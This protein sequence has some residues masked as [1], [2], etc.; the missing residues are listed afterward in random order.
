MVPSTERRLKSRLPVER[1]KNLLPL[2]HRRVRPLLAKVLLELPGLPQKV[3]LLEARQPA[4]AE[5]GMVSRRGRLSLVGA[6]HGMCITITTRSQRRRLNQP[7]HHLSKSK[8]TTAANRHIRRWLALTGCTT[9]ESTLE[10]GVTI[11]LQSAS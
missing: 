4:L 3:S 7:L 9:R 8:P 5:K 11:A 6:E 1:R 10:C 2:R